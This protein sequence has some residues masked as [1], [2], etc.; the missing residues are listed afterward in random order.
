MIKKILL[1]LVLFVGLVVVIFFAF[2]FFKPIITVETITLVNKP[3]N[4]AWKYFIDE[5]KL[6]EWM[7]NIKSI[8]KISGEPNKVGSKF[9]MTFEENGD[10]IVMTETMTEFRDNEVFGFT[11]ENEVISDDVRITFTDRGDKTEIVQTDKLTGGNIFWRSL[12]AILESTFHKNTAE[13]YEK[14]KARIEAQ[15]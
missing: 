15:P 10:E 12:F 2:G 11:L 14:L 8:E 5:S 6:K 9:K 13:T 3:R 7:T 4:V 1:G